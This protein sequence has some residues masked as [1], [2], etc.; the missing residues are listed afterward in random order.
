LTSEAPELDTDALQS[1]T[2]A[3]RARLREAGQHV[4]GLPA[5]YPDEQ[6]DSI[7]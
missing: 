3:M 5:A 1:S 6:T 4:S 7:A 2:A